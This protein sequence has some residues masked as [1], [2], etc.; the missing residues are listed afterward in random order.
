MK[1][2]ESSWRTC[3]EKVS[4]IS[5]VSA[6]FVEF[7]A[8]CH[9]QQ[10]R[11]SDRVTTIARLM[12]EVRAISSEYGA[13]REI[14]PE[15][16]QECMKFIFE[17]FGHLAVDE[18]RQAYRMWASEELEIKG[19]EFYGGSFNVAQIGKV[20]AAYNEK[21]K[22]VLGNYLRIVQEEKE[23]IEQEKRE[24]E[25]KARFEIEFP[26]RLMKAK[27]TI[28]DWREVPEYFYDSIQ[29]RWGIKFEPG[30]AQEIFED[31]KEI[32]RLEIAGT[33]A[34]SFSG[35]LKARFE[36]MEREKSFEEIAKVIARKIAVFRKIIKNPAFRV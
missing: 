27:E 31:A 19:A 28:T 33:L 13:R 7:V 26:A 30:E 17:K 35:G 1:L 24:Q 4:S 23:R 8:K 36:A 2:S 11:H 5:E 18:I 22:V 29:K 6:T 10:I 20:L 12:S 16:A 15:L 32:A 25:M 21:R 9:R 3:I 34:D 14:E